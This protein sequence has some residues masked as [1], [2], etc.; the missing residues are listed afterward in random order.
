MKEL[1][2]RSLN[3]HNSEGSEQYN[4]M[5]GDKSQGLQG[6]GKKMAQKQL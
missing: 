3:D 5:T 6:G 1:I 2:E 4:L